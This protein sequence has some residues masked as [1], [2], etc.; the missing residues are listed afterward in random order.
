M[1]KTY[2]SLLG[3]HHA[4][5]IYINGVEKRIVFSGA[6]GDTNGIFTTGKIEEQEAIEKNPSFNKR[7]ALYKEYK[8]PVGISG[9]GTLVNK[10][11]TSEDL[12]EAGMILGIPAK[13]VAKIGKI[14][15]HPAV[16]VPEPIKEKPNTK[17]F[18]TTNEAQEFF[19]TEYNIPKNKMRTYTE[20]RKVG[21]DNGLEI[22]FQK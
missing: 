11:L 20:I 18:K 14:T 8:D 22:I 19:M 3:Q 21:A 10:S 1:T 7:Y 15:N 5:S 2:I 6:E 12:K 13:E 17:T 16:A 4:T 9:P